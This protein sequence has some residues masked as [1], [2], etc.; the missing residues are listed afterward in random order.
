MLLS[1]KAPFKG[2][3]EKEIIAKIEKEK[4][5]YMEKDL[6]HLSELSKYLLAKMLRID[7]NKRVSAI[8]VL[9]DPWL[10]EYSNETKLEFSKE[11]L[12]ECFNNILNSNCSKKFQQICI[13]FM[14]HNIINE[15]ELNEIR[16]IF[17]Y[18]DT[19]RDGRLT[20]E[21]LIKGFKDFFKDIKQ[22][23]SF[24]KHLMKF[25]DDNKNYIEYDKFVMLA[26]S[27][28]NLI[29]EDVLRLTFNT[30]DKDKSGSISIDEM[31]DVLIVCSKSTEK[32]WLDVLTQI[33]KLKDSEI[34]YEMFKNLMMSICDN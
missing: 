3:G 19:K 12:K 13:L 16:G 33:D 22:Q 1:G 10:I 4:F 9:N 21:E 8:E 2:D 6:S 24:K 26:V 18:L 25:N 28:K 30:F 29:R 5:E 17:E 15:D 11:A 31:K 32:F 34:D 14:I 20:Y 7:P 27:K 23:K